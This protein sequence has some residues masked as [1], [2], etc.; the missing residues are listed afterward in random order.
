MI[1]IIGEDRWTVRPIVSKKGLT[2]FGVE[3]P[4]ETKVSEKFIKQLGYDEREDL[5]IHEHIQNRHFHFSVSSIERFIQLVKKWDYY[6]SNK[7][8]WKQSVSISP[9]S[10]TVNILNTN[11]NSATA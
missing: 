2:G 8:T 9:D 7:E 1:L 3:I 6:F 5:E 4:V 10:F 11:I